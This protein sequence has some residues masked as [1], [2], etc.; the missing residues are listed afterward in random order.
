M[1]ATLGWRAQASVAV[2]SYLY[3]YQ[4]FVAH[5]IPRKCF[6]LTAAQVMEHMRRGWYEGGMDGENGGKSGEGDRALARE[7]VGGYD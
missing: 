5:E 1:G 4:L 6:L 2:V 7:M 3:L